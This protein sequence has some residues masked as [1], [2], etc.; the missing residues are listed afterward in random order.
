MGRYG[1]I[2][3]VGVE[4]DVV[5]YWNS[6]MVLVVVFDMVLI[7]CFFNMNFFGVI[8]LFNIIIWWYKCDNKFKLVLDII[9][10]YRKNC[11]IYGI[12]N[13]GWRNEIFNC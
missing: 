5:V 13:G 2:D 7:Y 1:Y 3:C 12:S 8:M 6:C 10:I 4:F 9:V 11:D